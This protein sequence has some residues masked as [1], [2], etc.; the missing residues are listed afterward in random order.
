V[1]GG[2]FEYLEELIDS[3]L[4]DAPQLLSELENSIAGGA[5]ATVR[6]LAHSLK[7]NGADFGAVVFAGLCKD[8]E[9]LAT[10]GQLDGADRL[11]S[12]L[13]AE[14]VRIQTALEAVRRTGKL[15]G[16]E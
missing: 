11:A 1:V 14:Y 7:S 10:S 15:G 5:V 2:E 9:M 6:R 16:Y 4:E 8:L 12:Q 3:F 13:Q